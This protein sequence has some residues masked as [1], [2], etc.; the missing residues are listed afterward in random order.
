MKPSHSDQLPSGLSRGQKAIS[1]SLLQGE[2]S[3]SHLHVCFQGAQGYAS[4]ATCQAL[5]SLDAI[6]NDV[7]HLKANPLFLAFQVSFE[8]ILLSPVHSP[9]FAE[10]GG[11]LLV[12]VKAGSSTSATN[13]WDFNFP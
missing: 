12:S 5:V 6:R 1:W 11:I 2:G 9:Q 7:L 4:K 10:A 13:L 3:W 8:T